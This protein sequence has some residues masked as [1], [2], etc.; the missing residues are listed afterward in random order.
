MFL[1]LM[2]AYFGLLHLFRNIYKQLCIS[3]CNASLASGSLAL[4]VKLTS[5]TDV[6]LLNL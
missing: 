3:P 5:D 1:P 2:L 6:M 4:Q